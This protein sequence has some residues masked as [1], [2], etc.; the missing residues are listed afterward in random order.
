MH[1]RYIISTQITKRLWL[2]GSLVGCIISVLTG[3]LIYEYR[4]FKSQT[5]KMLELKEEYHTYLI[6]VKKI[7]HEY[8]QMK[9][10]LEHDDSD[11]KKKDLSLSSAHT[12]STTKDSSTFMVLN[13]Q[14]RH[15]I[16]STQAFLKK[17]N[18]QHDFD[19]KEWLPDNYLPAITTQSF[20]LQASKKRT[21]SVTKSVYASQHK[22]FNALAGVAKWYADIKLI[23]PIERS[24]FWLSSLF[25]YRKK[26]D[27]RTGFHYGI[28]LAALKGTPV[29]AAGSGT[30]VQA[31]YIKGYG[32]TVLI[33]HN[34]T[35]QTRY[36]H[37]DQIVVKQ[38]ARV[39]QGQLIGK[40]GHTGS[41]RKTG[42]YAD[43]LH[44]EVYRYGKQVNPI[45]FFIS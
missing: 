5:Y 21:N 9:L 16:H 30:V 41:V 2:A 28:D 32:N 33:T 31:S 17:H 19:F 12:L 15:L 3:L 37:L 11:Q 25:G 23:W 22:S 10:N 18:V 35:Y 45:Y 36:A 4:F 27:G 26:P 29:Y 43:H 20:A 13:R 38:G 39:V 34:S 8:N 14:P 44:L 1:R 40:V 24:Q 42:K 7:L 6:A